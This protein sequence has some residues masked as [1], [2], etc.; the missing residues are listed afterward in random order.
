MSLSLLSI[1]AVKSVQN[2]G[3]VCILD[4][5]V[6]GVRN[7][8]KSTLSPYY[9]FICPP[10]MD[11]LEARLRGRGTEI[12]EDIEKRLA[13]AQGE[14]DYGQEEGHF[15][16]HLVNDDLA[17]A[18]A[19]LCDTVKSWFPHLEEV[20][21]EEEKKHDIPTPTTG[22]SIDPEDF[23]LDAESQNNLEHDTLHIILTQTK[24]DDLETENPSSD[25]EL[26]NN[27]EHNTPQD[28]ITDEDPK[29]VDS[30]SDVVLQ[31]NFL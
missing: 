21:G 2:K 23:P 3:Q 4:I 11:D 13:N 25:A 10:S 1:E 5:D 14:M 6:Q 17:K 18:S 15:D 26:Q 24:D 16:K 12:E 29:A 20:D 30:S 7:V 28:N 22:D 31:S 8:K 27:L 9:V 19:D